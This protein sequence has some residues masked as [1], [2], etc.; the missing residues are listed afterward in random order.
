[1]PGLWSSGGLAAFMPTYVTYLEVSLNPNSAAP[2]KIV[3]SLKRLGWNAVYGQYDF[4]YTW[5]NPWNWDGNGGKYGGKYGGKKA[6]PKKNGGNKAFWTHINKAHKAL[7]DLN[8]TWSFR[9]YEKGREDF[10][11]RWND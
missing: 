2:S 10:Y 8:V 1:M 7:Q 6:A 5:E 3:N 9:T 11:V 4:A